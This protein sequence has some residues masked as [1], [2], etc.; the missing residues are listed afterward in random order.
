VQLSLSLVAALCLFVLALLLGLFGL[1]QQY[2]PEYSQFGQGLSAD[3]AQFTLR[4]ISL[5]WIGLLLLPSVWY[6]LRRLQGAAPQSVTAQP[7]WR[8]PTLWIFLLPVLLYLGRTIASQPALSWWLLPPLHVLSVSIPVAWLAYLAMH[9]INIG[10]LQRFWGLFSSSISISPLIIL[11]IEVLLL[12]GGL[13]LFSILISLQ[14]ELAAVLQTLGERLME[15]GLEPEIAQG[16]LAPYLTQPVVISSLLI[17]VGLVAPLIEEALKPLAMWILVNRSLNPAQGFA[18]GALCGAGYA[19]VESLALA[20][21]VEEWAVLVFVRIATG[22][23]HIL[24]SG[25]MGWG[26]AVAWRRQRYLTLAL[27]YLAAVALHGVWNSLTVLTTLV[28]FD[29]HGTAAQLS[30]LVR[31]GE[32]APYGLGALAIGGL[33]GLIMFNRIL[34]SSME[35]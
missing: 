31:G 2:I 7:A 30:W 19:L 18:A 16:I 28:R 27:A 20:S 9:Q 29:L 14:P 22:V 15:S 13:A 12:L 17:S 25:L 34:T 24:A 33:V 32:Y 35:K 11:I 10:S 3:V 23:I 5:F 8:R 26:L 4:A 1:L 21:Q 6:P